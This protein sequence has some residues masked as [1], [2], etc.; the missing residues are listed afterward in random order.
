MIQPV[1]TPVASLPAPGGQLPNAAEA[2]LFGGCHQATTRP[3][4]QIGARIG[5]I[6]P[7]SIKSGPQSGPRRPGPGLLATSGR[8][9]PGRPATLGDDKT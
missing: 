9:R 8:H 2:S 1:R 4:R 5:S 6:V 7:A 3:S